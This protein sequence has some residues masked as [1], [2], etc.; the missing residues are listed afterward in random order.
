MARNAC[1]S[2]RGRGSWL[3][4]SSARMCWN[5]LPGRD[6]TPST[7]ACDTRKWE[8]SGSGRAM[9]SLSNVVSD[10]LTK[11]SGGLRRTT[12]RF[13]A[14]SSPALAP[15]RPAGDL[16]E[17]PRGQQPGAPA[18]VLA[19]R[20]EQHG[21]DGHVDADAEGVGAADDLQQAGLGELF[22]QPP[23]FGQHPGVVDPDAVP[24]Q[25]GQRPAEA[26]REAEFADDV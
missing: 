21:A 24:D 14:G 12:F 7:I 23:V 1:R 3:P 2:C 13:L 25:P 22:H 9:T 4:S 6:T 17:L 15:A 5:A 10:Q 8:V 20:G 26:R 11:P 19:Q 16:V 18:V